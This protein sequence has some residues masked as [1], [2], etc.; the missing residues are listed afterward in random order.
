MSK[1][2]ISVEDTL[3]LALEAL[4]NAQAN[5]GEW[6][7]EAI[8]ALKEALANEDADAEIIKYHEETI[9]RLQEALTKQE[10]GEPVAL[11]WNKKMDAVQAMLGITS[12]E[13]DCLG[14]SLLE[15]YAN[16][17]ERVYKALYTTPQP[18]QEQGEPVAKLFG[19]LPVYDT[20]PQQRT[21]VGLTDEEMRLID[22]DGYEDGL[23]QQIQQAL[24]EKN[25]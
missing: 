6:W 14:E 12:G 24:K 21:W 13:L 20:T 4:Q 3:K 19:T 7:P 10:Q 15:T 1:E 22:P 5:F 23:P 18:K 11:T 17:V 9:A 8:T 2:A 16:D 25:T